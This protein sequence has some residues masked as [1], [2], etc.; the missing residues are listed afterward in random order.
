M[1]TDLVLALWQSA[2][3]LALLV[4]IA[5]VLR[6]KWFLFWMQEPK[7]FYMFAL[8]SLLFMGSYFGYSLKV[9][10]PL[11]IAALHAAILFSLLF[12]LVGLIN[13]GWVFGTAKLDRL[14]VMA[15]ALGLFMA[16]MT[17]QGMYYGPKAKRAQPPTQTQTP[18]LPSQ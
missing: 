3:L 5:G 2:P 17:L 9:G 16:F 11:I 18:N 8:G 14:W 4:V 1:P 7:P 13:P 10:Q 12:L 6:P 15:V